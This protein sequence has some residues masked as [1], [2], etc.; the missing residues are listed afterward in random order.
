MSACHRP[1]ANEE[2][3]RYANGGA[4]P[5]DLSLIT[6]ARSCSTISPVAMKTPLQP[7]ASHLRRLDHSF[8]GSQPIVVV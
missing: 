6:K 7:R 5:P 8:S 1:Y 2:A 4:Y 3:A